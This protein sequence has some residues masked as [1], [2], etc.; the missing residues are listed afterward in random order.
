MAHSTDASLNRAYTYDAAGNMM[1]NTGLCAGANTLAYP[2]PGPA[3]VR[4]HAPAS[5]CGAAVTY[6][7]NGNTASYDADGAGPLLVRPLT[8]NG[9]TVL[10]GKAWLNERYDAETGLQYLHR[11]VTQ[12]LRIAKYV[13]STVK[14]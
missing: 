4:P 7:A 12:F 1:M 14:H 11:V 8:S 5:I 6:D 3:L 9:S 2:A 10:N 13:I